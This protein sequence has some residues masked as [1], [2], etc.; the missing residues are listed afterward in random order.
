MDATSE[1][2]F[3]IVGVGTSAGGLEALE[4]FFTHM[5]PDNQMAFVVIQHLSPDYESHMVE[6]LSKYTPLKVHEA[7]D[8]VK[9]EPENIYL[10]PRRKN[11]TIFKGKLY[12]VESGR[13]QGLNLPIDIF[14]ESLAKDRS[15]KAIGII[16]SGTGSD[17]TRGIRAIKEMGGMVMVQDESAR[18]DG[19]PRSAISTQLVDYVLPPHAMPPSLL[20]YIKHPY[21][22]RDL[23]LQPAIADDQV[24]LEKLFAILRN[25]TGI[26]FSDYKPNTVLRRI[27]R[28]MS[29][30]QIDELSDYVRFLE[31]ASAESQLLYKEFLISVTRFFRDPEAFDIL[32]RDIV[33]ELFK[34]KRPQD[35]IRIWVP[36]CATG[37]EAYSL[38]ILFQEYMQET[39]VHADV[40][41][42]ATDIDQDAL[43]VASRG[44]YPESTLA[45][46][47]FE[48]LRDFFIKRGDS[49]EI[50]RHVRASVVFAYQNLVKDPP[51][52]RIDLVSCRNLLIYLQP[53]LQKSV[54]GLFQFA[55]RPQ[56]Y[57]LLGSSETVGDFSNVFTSHNNRWKI[58]RYDGDTPPPLRHSLGPMMAD[59]RPSLPPKT[60]RAVAAS[61][62]WHSSDTILRHLVEQMLPP[63]VVIDERQTVIHAFGDVR[64]YLEA[65]IGY[66]VNLNIMN[67]VRAELT[68]PLSTALHRT[69]QNQETVT[70]N[71]IR[72][73]E[74][75]GVHYINLTTRQFWERN[76]RQ[77][78]ILVQ[79]E[80]SAYQPVEADSSETFDLNQS[81]A[82]RIDDLEHQLQYT[83]E[84]LQATIEELETSNEELQATN[85]ELLAANEELQSTNEELQSV[86]E[87][88]TTVNNEYQLKIREL[89]HLNNDINNLLSATDIGTIFLDGNL[90][91]RRFTPAVQGTVNLI[92]QDVDRP[93]KHISHNLIGIDLHAYAERVLESKTG[94]EREAH[95]QN[96]NVYLLKLSPYLTHTH[97]ADGVVISLIDITRRRHA[98][99]ET[100]DYRSRLDMAM[101]AGNL[102]W[103]EIDVP[104]GQITFN[105]RKTDL[106]GY[107]ATNFTHYSDF[108]R[109]LHPDDYDPAMAAM[110]QHFE[111]IAPTYQIIY[112][113]RH[114][115][116]AYRWFQDIGQVV[117]RDAAGA[118]LTV[119][120]IVIDITDLKQAEEE[121]QRH[122]QTQ[123][124][125]A[126]SQAILSQTRHV[127]SFGHWELNLTT[128]QLH[129][130]PEVHT[131]FGT[132]P[133]RFDGT[134]AAFLECVHPDDRAAV[135]QVYRDSITS[136]TPY[137]VKHRILLADGTVKRVSEWGET[138]FDENGRATHS[139][140][141]VQELSVLDDSALPAPLQNALAGSDDIFIITDPN[142]P[143]NPIVYVNAAFEKHTGYLAVE[144]IGQNP[145]LLQNGDMD[146]PGLD[147]L[148]QAL[149]AGMPGQAVVRNYRKDGTPFSNN[150]AIYPLKNTAGHIVRW[151]GIQREVAES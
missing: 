77:R 54:M 143:G 151:L 133:E 150:V 31:H 132:V 63:C 138:F 56:G 110:R 51:F 7:R 123:A 23:S 45:D 47:S 28:R 66:Q 65:P 29:I 139:V 121:R 59:L 42:F 55:L 32:K 79:F 109:L 74:T 3:Y 112:R 33:P 142:L 145:R 82:Q 134:Y 100:D 124:E 20:S 48:R 116:G 78:L 60:P 135:E 19:M 11:M 129:W 53:H 147:T 50:L 144:V 127:A 101:Q 105:R 95:S 107:A 103:W 70:Y 85:E 40:K 2:E 10:I 149:A 35:Q 24:P 72:L 131:I 22:N 38:A 99:Q 41:I 61:A 96:G 43:D 4:K 97:Q 46:I 67:M 57:L 13:S 44:V 122:R 115:D 81:A 93:F 75:A 90:T 106:L 39:G 52:S 92:A 141:L 113:I 114:Q 71:H 49:Y 15:E 12:L 111:G 37:E 87:E 21:L 108:T 83:K 76:N 9:V 16:L 14:F 117:A 26:D 126:R 64:Q 130:S 125:L 148:R 1:A 36:G 6:L 120:G 91:V 137:H 146:Q 94:V 62:D 89:T 68:L 80:E 84:N 102:A 128:D 104:S 73:E 30:N 8:G 69:M 5:P 119:T 98:E 136:R 58:Y 25:R 27:A 140:G 18:F 86:N 34:G 17:G 88:L 118:P